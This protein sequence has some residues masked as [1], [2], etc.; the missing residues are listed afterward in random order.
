MELT[1][2]GMCFQA[3][4]VRVCWITEEEGNWGLVKSAGCPSAEG[5]VIDN[6]DYIAKIALDPGSG[7][8]IVCYQ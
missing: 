5:G 3:K 8:A 2:S 7:E 1:D 6:S 4:D